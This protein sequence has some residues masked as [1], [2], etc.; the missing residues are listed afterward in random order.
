VVPEFA[1]TTTVVVLFCGAGGLLLLM[2]PDKAA[3]TTSE[4][5]MVFMLNPLTSL[6]IFATEAAW[7][8]RQGNGFVRPRDRSSVNSY[9]SAITA[10]YRRRGADCAHDHEC[11]LN[12]SVS[13]SLLVASRM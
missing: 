2:H 4:A 11:A 10:I 5:S 3:S 7:S 8:Y 1:G 13:M 9:S 12:K 6:N